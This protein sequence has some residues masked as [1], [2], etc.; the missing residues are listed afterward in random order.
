MAIAPERF[1][2]DNLKTRSVDVGSLGFAGMFPKSIVDEC[3]RVP[4]ISRQRPLMRGSSASLKP[5]P[6]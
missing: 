5:S 1:F 3:R 6:M 4:T 2:A